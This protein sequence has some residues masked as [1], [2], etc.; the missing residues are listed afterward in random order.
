MLWFTNIELSAVRGRL[1]LPVHHGGGWMEGLCSALRGLGH[2]QMGVAAEGSEP[3]EPFDEDGVRYYYLEGPPARKGVGAAVSRWAHRPVDDRAVARAAT[4]VRSFEPNLIHVHGT[5]G[6]FG[7]LAQ[8]AQVPLV[9]S[10]QGLLVACSRAFF[11]GIP[12]AEVLRNTLSVEFAKGGGLVHSS[13]N[14]RTAAQRELRIMESCHFFTGRTEWDKSVLSVINATARYYR[15]DDVL[16]PEFYGHEWRPVPGG[17]FV[18][19]AIGSAA[20]YKGL[21]SLLEAVALLRD[22]VRPD[23]QLRVSGDLGVMWPIAQRAVRRLRL[24]SCIAWL[25]PLPTASIVSELEAASIYVH[26]SLVDNSPNALAEAMMV[27]VPCVASSAGGIPSMI[28]DG[29][30][31]LLCAPNDVY[32]LA[33]RLAT[34]EADAT[35]AVEL[36]RNARVRA[37]KRHDPG[38]IAQTTVDIYEDVVSRYRAASDD[39]RLS[40]IPPRA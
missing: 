22:S 36:G 24:E 3:F 21:I 26:P 12:P 13:W 4:A 34:V 27:G 7:L 14:M 30:D 6:P 20:P 40:S 1:S 8:T 38:A 28:R 18:V 15:L 32:G 37:L 16:R 17:P 9:T 10:L 29:T 39:E 5:E 25:G 33:G 35:L 31:G 2:V 19:Y 11:E 23:V